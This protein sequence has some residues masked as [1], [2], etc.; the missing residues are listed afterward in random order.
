MEVA[1]CMGSRL[2]NRVLFSMCER[3]QKCNL[4]AV[5]ALISYSF[6]PFLF[7]LE[8]PCSVAA[9][10]CNYFLFLII[11]IIPLSFG[12]FSIMLFNHCNCYFVWSLNHQC[13]CLGSFL[14]GKAYI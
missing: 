5:V 4:L 12:C 6:G 1:H 11:V 9:Q 7:E 8:S 3:K 2:P 14:P 13:A 10:S